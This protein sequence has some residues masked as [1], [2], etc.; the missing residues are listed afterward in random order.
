MSKHG[1]YKN[2]YLTFVNDLLL[3]LIYGV[4]EQFSYQSINRN[5]HKLIAIFTGAI[6]TTRHALP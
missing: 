5:Y 4:I 2:Y 3:L 1:V 6:K